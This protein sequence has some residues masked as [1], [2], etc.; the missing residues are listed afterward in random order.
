MIEVYDDFFS[1][2]IQEEIFYKLMKP[3][4]CIDGDTLNKPEIFWHYNGLEKVNILMNIFI[5]KY[6]LN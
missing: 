4:W 3:H 6:V 2:E 1:R 5:K